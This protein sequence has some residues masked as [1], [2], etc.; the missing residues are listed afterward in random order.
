MANPEALT[1]TAE[2]SESEA[3]PPDLVGKQVGGKYEIVRFIACGGMGCVYEAKHGELG[4]R[5]A[6]KFLRAKFTRRADMVRR[7]AR[8]AKSA[9]ALEC[10][11]IVAVTDVGVF[12]DVPYLVME[13]L[14]G[15][16][17]STLLRELG[18]LPPKRAADIALQVCRGLTVAHR[19]GIVHRDLKPA[20]IFLCRRS[21]GTDQ[22]KLLDFGIA[23][24]SDGDASLTRPGSAMGSAHYMA[25]EQARGAK[26]VDARTDVYA[27]GAVLYEAISGNKAHPGDGYDE[28][29]YRVL[30]ERPA[31]LETLCPGVPAALAHV[32]HRALEAEPDQ[33]FASADEL[34]AALVPLAFPERTSGSIEVACTT[35]ATATATAALDET[36]SSPT[37][38]PLLRSHVDTKRGGEGLRLGAA[39]AAVL[40]LVVVVNL[41]LR[42]MARE[43]ILP[44][45]SPAVSAPSASASAV[46]APTAYAPRAPL[47]SALSPLAATPSSVPAAPSPAPPRDPAKS[48][49]S[50]ASVERAALSRGKG[51]PGD[52]PIA[53]PTPLAV[54]RSNPYEQ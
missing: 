14:E 12:G 43:P 35:P 49:G 16:T 11:H 23:K 31:R 28:V 18:A 20:N 7:F 36:A 38:A 17:L 51:A 22:A 6:I 19:A 9:A 44:T 3:P 37:P 27:L 41:A 2:T 47:P 53:A 13:Y 21:D 39:A 5:F 15:K 48:P 33:R 54:D 10:E 42:K 52:H 30:R 4:R 24:C 8:E 46:A 1:I 34:A 26:H 45:S 25:P 40:A 32:V 50:R 29:L